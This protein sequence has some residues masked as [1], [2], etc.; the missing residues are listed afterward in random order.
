MDKSYRRIIII[1]LS[2]NALSSSA[3]LSKPNDFKYNDI[4]F[5]GSFALNTYDAFY[6]NYDPA[7][8]RW[9]EIDPAAEKFFDLN[10]YNFGFN[11]P[12]YWSDTFGNCPECPADAKDGD[13]ASPNG[14]QYIYENGEWVRVPMSTMSV[15]VTPTSSSEAQ[16]ES[17]AAQTRLGDWLA[18]DLN[19]LA[20]AFKNYP[21]PHQQAFIQDRFLEGRS[22]A[23]MDH[24]VTQGAITLATAP[25]PV[26][27]L[28]KYGGKIIRFGRRAVDLR[29]GTTLYR[30]VSK[31]ELDDIARYG[32][33]SRGGQFGYESGKLFATSLDDAATF[34]R[35]NFRFDG[36]PNFLLKVRA[37]R[38]AMKQA[39]SFGADGMNAVSIPSN[40]LRTL[41]V[42]PLNFSPIR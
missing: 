41:T 11:D 23:F 35:N 42:K 24:P 19:N 4:E 20:W 13:T 14:I 15:E 27:N 37:P 33:R 38:S 10:P 32:L 25:L 5:N 7:I 28:F 39:F 2:I 17:Q 8:G 6:R 26:S 29:R 12:G 40:Q 36:T 34:G 16:A 21:E 31:A 9:W 3:P 22:R 18:A 1:P 30:A